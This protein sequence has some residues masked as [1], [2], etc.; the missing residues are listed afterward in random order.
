MTPQSEYAYYLDRFNLK[1]EDVPAV[2]NLDA[3][4]L[5]TLIRHAKAGTNG[6]WMTQWHEP[7]KTEY[8]E[9]SGEEINEE[10]WCKTT[11][12]RAGYAVCLAGKEGWNLERRL[13]PEDAGI[14]IYFKSVGHHPNF[15]AG[16]ED[17]LYDI[18]KHAVKQGF[19][20]T[21]ADLKIL[22]ERYDIEVDQ[23]Q[24]VIDC[25]EEKES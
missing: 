11:H 8:G 24:E 19:T 6:L 1:D 14:M 10:N 2:P 20:P 3:V 23:A 4:M 22:S 17:A 21:T 18:I 7:I 5:Q 16:T 9:T 13:D 12:C 25:E 15:Y